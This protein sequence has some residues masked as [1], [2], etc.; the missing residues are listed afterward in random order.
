MY[1][2]QPGEMVKSTGS[3]TT[4]RV[5]NQNSITQGVNS[6]THLISPCLCFLISK[7]KMAIMVSTS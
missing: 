4:A 2:R 5:C 7:M 6:S 3:G 1:Q